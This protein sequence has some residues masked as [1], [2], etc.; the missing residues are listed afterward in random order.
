M[1]VGVG[2]RVGWAGGGPGRPYVHYLA[3]YGTYYLSLSLRERE[4][5]YVTTSKGNYR[6]ATRQGTY[7][8]VTLGLSESRKPAR[9]R[10]V[11]ISFAHTTITRQE[12]NKRWRSPGE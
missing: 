6:A 10:F 3:W 12:S 1:E 11:K 8:I 4:V 5:L 9:P 7:E 2:G